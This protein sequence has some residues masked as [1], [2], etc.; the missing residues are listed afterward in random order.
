MRNLQMSERH[1]STNANVNVTLGTVPKRAA[2]TFPCPL[3]MSDLDLRRSRANKPYCV[4]NSCGVQVFFRGKKGIARLGEFTTHGG[5]GPVPTEFANAGA[6][7]AHLERLRAYR[8]DL[9]DKR[10]L[11]FSDKD[12]ENAILATDFEIARTQH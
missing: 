2:G 5:I 3:C 11:I 8:N 6:V 12:L 10:P 9:D 1:E 4:C 7:F